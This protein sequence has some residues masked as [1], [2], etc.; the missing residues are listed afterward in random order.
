MVTF[1]GDQADHTD[2]GAPPGVASDALSCTRVL[3]SGLSTVV[4]NV[5]P[6]A[7]PVKRSDA[8]ASEAAR[9]QALLEGKADGAKA[10]SAKTAPAPTG[11]FVVQF[12]SYSDATRA[13]EA[14]VKVERAGFKTYAQIAQG[15]DGKR[16]RVRVGPFT[17]R[18]D[19]EKAAEKIKKLD[20]PTNILEL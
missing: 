6:V 14:R 2:A 5:A 17:R 12:G 7:K 9:A 4:P 16:Y 20:L 11:R 1:W 8:A 10:D 19:A 3:A 13:H 15:A 18:A